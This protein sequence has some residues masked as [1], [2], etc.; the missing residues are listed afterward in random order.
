MSTLQSLS[1]ETAFPPAW[2]AISLIDRI[3]G[4][5]WGKRGTAAAGWS[6]WRKGAAAKE[7]KKEAL[8]ILINHPISLRR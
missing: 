4:G 1:G 5:R 8:L 6:R 3:G 2:L 7:H